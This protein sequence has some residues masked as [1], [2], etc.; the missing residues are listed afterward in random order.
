MERPGSALICATA[1][2]SSA[3]RPGAGR[4]RKPRRRR[5]GQRPAIL[6]GEPRPVVGRHDGPASG[7]CGSTSRS[8][9]RPRA[10]LSSARRASGR[11][12]RLQPPFAPAASAWTFETALSIRTYSKVRRVS[13]RVEKPLP[14]APARPAPEPRVTARGPR[15]ICRTPPAGHASAPH[16]RPSA[17]SH[18]RTIGCRRR[19][20]PAFPPGREDVPRSAPI[21][22]PSVF[23]CSRLASVGALESEHPIKRNP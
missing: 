9:R 15:S 17:R 19:S 12:R 23:V 6:T 10:A 14:N 3:I 16:R 11:W 8:H 2:R 22:R 20:A 13:Q 7:G 1:P 5:R 18:P 21:A 4:R